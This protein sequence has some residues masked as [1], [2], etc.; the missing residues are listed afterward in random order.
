MTIIV[1]PEQTG[2]P[3]HEGVYVVRYRFATSEAFAWWDG[4]AWSVGSAVA[5]FAAQGLQAG[6]RMPL[7]RRSWRPVRYWRAY[8]NDGQGLIDALRDAVKPQ[9]GGGGGPG[10]VK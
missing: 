7:S 5:Y 2:T 3:P 8:S 10:P 4:R 1:G 9:G 6:Q